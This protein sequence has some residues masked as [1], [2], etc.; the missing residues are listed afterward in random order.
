MRFGRAHGHG[1][2]IMR[3]N[4]AM[5]SLVVMLDAG[6]SV[7]VVRDET[8]PWLDFGPRDDL[9][10]Q[11]DQRTQETIGNQLALDGWEVISEDNSGRGATDDGLSHSAVYIVRNLTSQ[12]PEGA[13]AP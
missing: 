3:G 8:I 11:I 7:T 12:Y 10:W 4:D 5:V 9:G 1:R 6:S 2:K 13:G